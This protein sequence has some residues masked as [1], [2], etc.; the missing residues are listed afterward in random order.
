M[1]FEDHDNSY[2]LTTKTD[3]V[4]LILDDLKRVP[5]TQVRSHINITS[6]YRS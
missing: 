6:I 4:W 2:R 3:R 5:S 1:D